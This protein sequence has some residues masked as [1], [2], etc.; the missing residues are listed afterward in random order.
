MTSA[1]GMH[2]MAEPSSSAICGKAGPLLM[3]VGLALPT[4]SFTK[5]RPDRFKQNLTRLAPLVSFA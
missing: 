2:M 5:T 3:A 4:S 1:S